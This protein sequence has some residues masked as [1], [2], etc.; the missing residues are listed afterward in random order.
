MRYFKH[1]VDAHRGNSM[2]T[3]FD[4]FGHLGP[5]C[6]W[7]LLEMCADKWWNDAAANQKVLAGEFAFHLRVMQQTMRTSRGKVEAWLTLGATL[8]LFSFSIVDNKVTILMPKLLELL[9]PHTKYNRKRIV[10]ASQNDRLEKEEEREEEKERLNTMAEPENSVVDKPVDN[11]DAPQPT[12]EPPKPTQKKQTYRI[13]NPA[14]FNE[15]MSEFKNRWR[16]LYPDT[17]FLRRE[18]LKALN[19]LEANPSKALR[20]RKGWQAFFA[21]WFEKGWDDHVKRGPSNKPAAQDT[22]AEMASKVKSALEQ[23]PDWG[24]ARTQAVKEFLGEGLYQM[25]IQTKAY[26]ARRWAN[27]DFYMRKLIGRLKESTSQGG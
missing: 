15:H 23:W 2:N 3:L 5:S 19:W 21:N 12:S 24:G 1:V 16:E 11:S 18:I 27:D 17:E 10:K 25:A 6:Y 9:D 13:T 22:W 7:I 26:E 14:E 8:D 4:E 20:T